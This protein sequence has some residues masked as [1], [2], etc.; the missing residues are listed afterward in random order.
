MVCIFTTVRDAG[1]LQRYRVMLSIFVCACVL[2]FVRVCQ[3]L[4][5]KRAA[6][7]GDRQI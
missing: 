6:I 3:D 1:N 4:E 7:L 5:S 2:V